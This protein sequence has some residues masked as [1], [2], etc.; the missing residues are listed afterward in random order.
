MYLY[1]QP[2]VPFQREDMWVNED[3]DGM[4]SR[5]IAV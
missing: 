3:R 2:K 1:I 4:R 5:T